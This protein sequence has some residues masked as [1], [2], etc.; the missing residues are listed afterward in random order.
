MTTAS[1]WA[2]PHKD[3][4]GFNIILQA[5]PFNAKIADRRKFI[6]DALHSD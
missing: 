3:E 6:P 5:I 2:L 1:S 4:K